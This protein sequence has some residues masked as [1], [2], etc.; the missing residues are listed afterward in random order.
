ML[1][2]VKSRKG[3]TLTEL[4]VVVAII[5][6]LMICVT[7]FVGPISKMVEATTADTDAI[8]INE[9]AGD[10]IERRLAYA[11]CIKIYLASNADPT[12]GTLSNA[13]SMM[14]GYRGSSD[15]TGMLIFKMI[16]DL[17]DPKSNTYRIYDVPIKGSGSSSYISSYTSATG[18]TLPTS[19]VFA[20]DYYGKYQH[21]FLFDPQSY[22][23]GTDKQFNMS[24]NVVKGKAFLDFDIYSYSFDT[25]S[26]GNLEPKSS[27]EST[28]E[29]F[30]KNKIDSVT[31]TD[32]G[33]S[34]LTDDKTAYEHVS[35][36]LQN[37]GI[38]TVKATTTVNGIT[39][40]EEVG[41][42]KLVNSYYIG[43]GDDIVIFYNVK[44][45]SPTLFPPA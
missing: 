38:S 14:Q 35:F 19:P 17:S 27:S 20:E 37:I 18:V 3:F 21:I 43:E 30:Y 9:I 28:L 40:E 15:T 6:L 8:T 39:V 4:I 26:A 1:R 5:A 2:R 33:I 45:Y 31:N 34:S 32:N 22:R 41:I 24:V 10:Y 11:D 16:E 7:A 36:E 13:Y 23:G 29:K 42:P 44:S 25:N 12:N